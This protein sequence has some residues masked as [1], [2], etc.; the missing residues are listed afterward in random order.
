MSAPAFIFDPGFRMR[1]RRFRCIH[2]PLAWTN[3]T[4]LPWCRRLVL[5]IGRTLPARFW[6][7]PPRG[8]YSDLQELKEGPANSGDGRV[9]LRD[10][11]NPILPNPSIMLLCRRTQHQ[12][13]PWPVFWRHYRDV[14]LAGHSLVHL[15]RRREVSLEAIYGAPRLP[16]D[17]AWLQW[18]VKGPV[19]LSGPW[20]SVVNRWL[21]NRGKSPYAHWLLDALPRLAI[22][23]QFPA[24][25]RV[26][27]PHDMY[28]SQVQS[29][30]I[31][32][33]GDRIRRTPE[34]HVRVQDYYFSSPPS[35]I[36]CYSPYSV[37]AVRSMFFPRVQRAAQTPT[38]FFVRR[39]S[40]GR[41]MINEREVLDFFKRLGWAII[42]AA[43]LSFAEQIQWFAGAEAVCAI[44]GSGT[45]NMVWCSPRC[46]F[47][48]MFAA[49][50]L[51]GDQEWIAQCV[52]VDYHFMIFPCDYKLDAQIDLAEL[53]RKLQD[54]DLW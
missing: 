35:M 45:A 51:A 54:L 7:A 43:A 30:E 20:T 21:P 36:V 13:Q 29:L 47:I 24:D 16:G 18:P 27:V 37:Q 42:D 38:R 6:W 53:K 5:A 39:T 49:D 50:Y 34:T 31:L 23:D 46:K 1:L 32:G 26:I 3:R 15:N 22:L 12:Q 52:Q 2:A 11:G 33:L 10:Q 19:E 25:T 9:I 48:E 17:P 40:V 44:H 41:N 8:A 14:R 28:K 4:F